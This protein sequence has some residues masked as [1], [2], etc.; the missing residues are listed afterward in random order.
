MNKCPNPN[1][2]VNV[3]DGA[4]F[5][6]ECGTP[7]PQTKECPSCHARWPLMAKFCAECGYNFNAAETSGPVIGD[8]NVIAGDVHIDQSS[9]VTNNTVNNINNT[10]NNVVNNVFNQDDTKKVVQCVVCGKQLPIVESCV[11]TCC[12]GTVCKEHFDVERQLC[13]TC[14]SKQAEDNRESFKRFLLSAYD[15]CNAAD[16]PDLLYKIDKQRLASGLDCD[17][18]LDLL[19]FWDD[20]VDDCRPIAEGIEQWFFKVCQLSPRV[21]LA[22]YLG[23]CYHNGVGLPNGKISDVEQA[24][25]V[26]QDSAKRGNEISAQWL[27]ELNP[28]KV[29]FKIK[30]KSFVE[31]GCSTVDVATAYG[32][33]L[34]E[35]KRYRAIAQHQK[36]FMM[37][38]LKD[39]IIEIDESTVLDGVGESRHLSY[40]ETDFEQCSGEMFEVDDYDYG[41]DGGKAHLIVAKYH[42]GCEFLGSAIISGEFETS[43]LEIQTEVYDDNFCR[44]PAVDGAAMIGRL[45]A[46]V[47]MLHSLS[48][49]GEEIAVHAC[50]GYW[51]NCEVFLRTSHLFTRTEYDWE[52]NVFL[53]KEHIR[54]VK[55]EVW[56]PGIDVRALKAATSR[57]R[58]MTKY[59]FS[60]WDD[61]WNS[62]TSTK[63]L[64]DSAQMRVSDAFSGIILY[65]GALIGNVNLVEQVRDQEFLREIS[66]SE[67]D[68]ESCGIMVLFDRMFTYHRKLTCC[69]DA[70]FSPSLVDV[71]WFKLTVFGE[72][73]A[74][75]IAGDVMD[76]KLNGASFAYSEEDEKTGEPMDIIDIK[77]WL[78]YKDRREAWNV[79]TLEDALALQAKSS[80]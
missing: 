58:D 35:R 20:D 59:D 25:K 61:T 50:G 60:T 3:E 43:K 18:V 34:D 65:E 26:Y 33:S 14:V 56:G 44:D 4:K 39:V 51:E 75:M 77:T 15:L 8:K 28:R 37:P 23:R 21:E 29:Y 24:V 16:D 46:D 68:T 13:N 17:E 48:Y 76:F 22:H 27:K 38:V 67:S 42:D 5:C 10:T 69:Y 49:E 63:L 36:K 40:S 53:E 1:C 32:M 31:V 41:E 12:H 78:Q 2:G 72:N 70:A 19:T 66:P 62:F 79:L 64:I 80:E 54:K 57:L 73:E 6:M 71:P 9:A 7:I 11:C 30:P 47:T 74:R 45:G 52:Y 55:V